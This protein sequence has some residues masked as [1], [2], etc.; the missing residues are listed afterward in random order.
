MRGR[1]IVI[2]G[3]AQSDETARRYHEG[4]MGG[5]ETACKLMVPIAAEP[6]AGRAER[7]SV[8]TEYVKA[9]HNV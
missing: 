4:G 5:S 8:G 3:C 6:G 1:P 7:E 2:R 9:L